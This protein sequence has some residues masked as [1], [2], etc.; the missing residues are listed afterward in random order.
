[1]APVDIGHR[2]PF[3]TNLIY[4]HQETERVSVV[5]DSGPDMSL[6]AHTDPCPAVRGAAPRPTY[7][8]MSHP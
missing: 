6:I 7:T 8:P 3:C 2:C 1:M 5:T 4:P